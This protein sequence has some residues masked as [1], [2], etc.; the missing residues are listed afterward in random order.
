[1]NR[2]G[3]LS[4]LH[5]FPKNGHQLTADVNYNKFKND[6]SSYISNYVSPVLGGPQTSTYRQQ[7]LNNGENGQLVVQT[8]YSNPI[9]D[10]TKFEAGAK[11]SQRDVDSKTDFSV[12]NPDNTLTK[13]PTLSSNYSYTER[14]YA[15][16]STYSS[17]IKD[18]F[19]YQMGLRL[20]GSEYNGTV[21]SSVKDGFGFKD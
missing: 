7:Q 11:M 6:N 13:L 16:Y 4:Y 1:K 15:A 18:K 8:D 2:G 5:N 19:G 12:I 9:N 14:I 20:E 3:A 21:H 10:K 17:R